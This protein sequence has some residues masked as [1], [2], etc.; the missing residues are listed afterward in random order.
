MPAFSTARGALARHWPEYLIEGW[1]LGLFMISAATVTLLVELPQ[2]PLRQTVSDPLARR[3]LIGFA[4][5]LTAIALIYS[6][7]GRRSGAHMNPAVT[8]AYWSLG[9]VTGA[10]A[11]FYAIAQ[12]VGG[13]LGLGLVAALAGQALAQP[14]INFVATQPGPTGVGAAFFAEVVISAVL[15]SVVLRVAAHPRTA[16]WTGLCAGLLVMVYITVEAPL[17]GMSM[18]PARSFASALSGQ[19]WGDLWIYF[20]APPLGM[21]FAAQLFRHTSLAGR[22]CAKLMHAADRDCLFCGQAAQRAMRIAPITVRS[23]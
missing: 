12:F 6:G 15:M 19:V 7:W 14:Q 9:R 10:D 20:V 2:S 8:L 1:A 18:N 5:G 16:P 11:T 23:P 17:S 13:A 22:G 21:V 3:A 4:M